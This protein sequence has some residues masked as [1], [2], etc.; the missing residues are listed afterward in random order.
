MACPR[1]HTNMWEEVEF[2]TSIFFFHT[3]PCL[4]QIMMD[5]LHQNFDK[6]ALDEDTGP[7]HKSCHPEA[8]SESPWLKGKQAESPWYFAI[9]TDVFMLTRKASW[10]FR[11]YK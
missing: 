5:L 9:A 7:T 4:V 1:W 8:S 10:H 2:E 11:R 3:N 6:A